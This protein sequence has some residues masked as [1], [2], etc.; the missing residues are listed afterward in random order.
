MKFQPLSAIVCGC[1]LGAWVFLCP[2]SLK[3]QLNTEFQ[4]K[5]I[6][7]SIVTSPSIS[8]SL[9]PQKSAHSKNWMEIEVSFDW[10]PQS[11][12][13]RYADDVTVRYYLL[14]A[15]KSPLF[16]EGTLLTGEVTHMS[17]PAVKKGYP[18]SV[19]YLSPRTMQRFF[20]GKIP[21]NASSA[22]VDVGVTI[23][24]HDQIV[25][26]GSLRGRGSWWSQYRQV[27][28]FLLSKNESPFA[29]LYPDYYEDIKPKPESR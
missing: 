14:L 19:M 1:L 22:L 21:S 2:F 9:A 13:E 26:A 16:P 29:S 7:A 15:N 11:A 28:G 20:N 6:E 18:K 5:K 27:E 3:A 10:R 4:V 17:V 24:Y 8:Y 25:A 23:S 12:S